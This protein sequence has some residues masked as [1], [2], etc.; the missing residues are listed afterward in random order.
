[1]SSLLHDL[2]RIATD[3]NQSGLG[4]CLV[5]GLAAS[6]YAEPRTT[7]DVDVAVSVSGE[8]DLLQ[9]LEFESQSTDHLA[10]GCIL[11]EQFGVMLE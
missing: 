8:G 2:R 7:K 3:M 6:V 10:Q 4:W 9:L 11:V 1:M 5:G